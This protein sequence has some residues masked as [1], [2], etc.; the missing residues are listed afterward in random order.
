MRALIFDVDGVL[1]DTEGPVAEASIRMFRETYGV[2]MQ[3]EDFVPFIGTGAQRFV[4]G[5]A[6]KYGVKIDLEVAIAERHRHF[7]EIIE[8][9]ID[10]TFPGVAELLA[11][12]HQDPGWKLAIATSSPGEKSRATLR[13]A[14][15]DADLFDV[16][17]HGDMITRKKP[18]PEIYLRAASEL[19]LSPAEC[20]VVEDAITGVA[21]GKAAGMK[22]VAVTNSFQADELAAADWIAG[23]LEEVTLPALEKLLAS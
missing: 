5:P 16:Y 2:D 10:I 9:G 22:V 19:G 3:P 18:D 6:E 13:A 12:A 15:V 14:K 11:A 21:S 7:V 8:S 1:G 20:V 23:S 17:V 4:E